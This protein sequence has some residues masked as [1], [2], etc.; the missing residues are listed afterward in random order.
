MEK[1]IAM[2]TWPTPEVMGDDIAEGRAV[3]ILNLRYGLDLHYLRTERWGWFWPKT[4]WEATLDARFPL[5]LQRHSDGMLLMGDRHEIET[6]LGSVPPPLRSWFPETE[7]P[8]AYYM[9]DSGYKYGGFWC[10]ETL[11]SPWMF[12]RFDR[13]VIDGLCLLDAMDA[14]GVTPARRRTI[15]GC[16]R[17]F[18]SCRFKPAPPTRP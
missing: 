5:M 8:A 12:R 18:G 9:H 11:D 6:D 10:A 16:V 14:G 1:H 17:T 13:A 3:S 15:H 4:F 7:L 2:K